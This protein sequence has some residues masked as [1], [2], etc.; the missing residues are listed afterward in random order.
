MFGNGLPWAVLQHGGIAL[1]LGLGSLAAR[2]S[3][4]PVSCTTV[5]LVYAMK[6]TAFRQMDPTLDAGADFSAEFEAALNM[7]G[8]PN[9][10]T[11]A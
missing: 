6:Y 10:S 2:D 1:V 8:N 7:Q 9:G 3:A 5:I 4:L 11:S